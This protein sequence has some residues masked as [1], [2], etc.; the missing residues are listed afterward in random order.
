M[1]T[2]FRFKS[3]RTRLAFW[4]LLVTMLNL[5]TVVTFLYF[6]RSAIIRSKEFEKLELARDLKVMEINSWL[7]ERMADLQVAAGDDDIRSLKKVL[8]KKR[9]DWTAEDL[10]AVSTARALLQRYLGVYTA[11]HEVF[12]IGA[13]SGRTVIQTTQSLE[14]RDKRKFSYFIEPMRTGK[15]FIQDVYHSDVENKP[16]MAFAAPVVCLDHDGEHVIGVLVMRVDLEQNLYPLLQDRTGA[17]ETGETLIINKDGFALN[18]LRW[19]EG[20]PLSL[21]INAKPAMMAVG[22]E[23]GIVETK[24]YRGVMVLAAY[25]H[26]PLMR[27]G[28]VVKRDLAEI[29]APIN[30]LLRQMFALVLVS[31][32]V[33]ILVSFLLSGTIARPVVGISTIV[34][35]FAAG[36]LNARC[37]TKGVDEV[38]AL[39]T[40]FNEMAAT[41]VSQMTIQ[42]ITSEVADTMVTANDMEKFASGL[43]IKLID[44]SGSHLGAFYLRSE[45]G[46]RLEPIASVGLS[47]DAARSFSA[48]GH[49]G[50][51]GQTLATGKVATLRDISPDTAFTF[52]TTGGT[53]V[54]REIMTIPLI[55]ETRVMAVVSLATLSAYS[56]VHSEIIDRAQIGMN[57]KLSNLMANRKTQALADEL[58][59]TNT[60]LTAQASKLVAQTT[61]LKAQRDKLHAQTMEL[62]ARRVQ[63]EEADKLKSKFLS[64]MSH[65]LRTPL[66]SIMTLSQLMINRGVDKDPARAAEYLKVIDRNGRQLLSLINDILDLAKI[67]SGSMDV[68]PTKFEAQRIIDRVLE[69]VTPIA[70]KKNIQFETSIDQ[71]SLLFSDEDKVYQILLNLCSNAIKFSE[72]GSVNI[73]VNTTGGKVSFMVKDTGIGISADNLGTIFDQ[74]RQV[75]GSFTR[76]Q[77][78]T[79]LGLAISKKLAFLLGGNITVE[80]TLGVG[81]TFT[82]TLPISVSGVDIPLE[83]SGA[84]PAAPTAVS[85]RQERSTPDLPRINQILVVEDNK[86]ASEQIVTVLQENGFEVV[87]AKDGVEGLAHVKRSIPAGIILDLMMPRVDGFQVLDQIR[88]RPET[89]R[90]P[91]LILTAKEI[92]A[93]ERAHLIQNNIQQLIQKGTADRDQLV[94]SVRQ[95]VGAPRNQLKKPVSKTALSGDGTI[96]M[97]ED[98]ADNRLTITAILEDDGY[99]LLVAKNGEQGVQMAEEK[100]PDLILMDI[101]LPI[102]SGIDAIKIL[103][104]NP[105]TRA[106]PIIAVTARAMKGDRENILSAGAEDYTS[107]PINPAE[108]QE[109]VRKWMG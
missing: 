93:S 87:V 91:V 54:P 78:G 73:A 22:G 102:M 77:E 47:D 44:M 86:I 71:I 33:V 13:T 82:L 23:T 100:M 99:E 17:G 37:A 40:L 88:S 51:L 32:L 68:S 72:K 60:E 52:K 75:D 107:K 6:Q 49:E 12:F 80:S 69:T 74:F 106:I 21:K 66:N 56:N 61:E 18:E 43:L 108:L 14:G 30:S 19:H 85:D 89:A 20:A 5:I 103:K 94:A 79:G 76:A 92:T 25:T 26:I 9:D 83:T 96:L 3:V 55:A 59:G 42:Q 90:I 63:V 45:D 50:E 31:L 64:N 53:A 104:K 101:Q 65:E 28:F 24:D 27:W 7:K 15:P 34:R 2:F 58:L 10:K 81:S 16:A 105:A 84:L 62:A 48:K 46:Q 29:Y 97:V 57:T 109:K 98:N 39:G 11:Y 95:L 35:R 4:F 67:E 36:D 1:N 38:A 70:Q 8:S 41:L